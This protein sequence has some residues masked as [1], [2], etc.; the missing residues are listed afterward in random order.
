M[1]A[2]THRIYVTPDYAVF[3]SVSSPLWS[4]LTSRQ[5]QSILS[6]L[7]TYEKNAAYDSGCSV[8]GRVQVAVPG[9]RMCGHGVPPRDGACHTLPN[10]RYIGAFRFHCGSSFSL[11]L[12]PLT[13]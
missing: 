3:L 7:C 13:V 10:I 12:S 6:E 8:G 1:N 4:W 2:P 9:D 5:V 11:I